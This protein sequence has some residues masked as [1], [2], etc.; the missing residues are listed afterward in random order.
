MYGAKKKEKDGEWSKDPLRLRE[1]GVKGQGRNAERNARK[2]SA[3]HLK[4]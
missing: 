4:L 3:L 2:I 1:V